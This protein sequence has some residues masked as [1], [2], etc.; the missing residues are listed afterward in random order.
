MIDSN[1]RK[2]EQTETLIKQILL[3]HG[4]LRFKDIEDKTKVS[5][6]TLSKWSPRLEEKG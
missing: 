6:P 1:L 5:P 2:G 3:E 4:P